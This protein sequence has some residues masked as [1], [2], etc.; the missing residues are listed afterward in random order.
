M[1]LLQNTLLT[2]YKTAA[3]LP[4]TRPLQLSGYAVSVGDGDTFR[5]VHVP[6]FSSNKTDLAA[7]KKIKLT[8]CSIAV[9]LAAVDTP[10]AAHFGNPAQPFSY[11]SYCFTLAALRGPK[12]KISASH[13]K[14]VLKGDGTAATVPEVVDI[15]EP[16]E[17]RI[18]VLRVDQYGRIVAMVYYRKDNRPLSK[19]RNLAFDLLEEGL[20]LVYRQGGAEYGGMLEDFNAAEERAK[21]AKRG[22]WSLSNFQT[23][24]QYKSQHKLKPGQQQPSTSSAALVAAAPVAATAAVAPAAESSAPA[25]RGRGRGRGRGAAG[26]GAA[27]GGRSEGARGGGRKTTSRR[28]KNDDSDA[29]Y[30]DDEDDE[31][32]DDDE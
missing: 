3:D 6:T 16:R 21:T 19:W 5:F 31:D 20:G 13:A 32:Y 25:G 15:G 17:V 29:D 10:E 2:Q 22:I 8:E 26:R 30:V 1:T 24:A 4:P 7:E 18:D 28:K 9:R 27:H 11:E 14:K 12:A 23:P